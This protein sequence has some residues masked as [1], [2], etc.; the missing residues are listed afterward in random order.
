MDQETRFPGVKFLPWVGKDYR[1]S[2]RFRLRLLALGQ[3]HYGELF[4]KNSVF[5]REVVREWGQRNPSSYFTKIAQ[6]L[7]GET[8][9]LSDEARTDVWEHIAFYNYIQTL[10]DGPRTLP[11]PA[12]WKAAE[13]PFMV[14]LGA[15]QP[16]A[17]LVLGKGLWD[18]IRCRPPDVAF[19]Q[20]YDP[21][22][23]GMSVANSIPVLNSL[24]R[25]ASTRSRALHS[26]QT[27]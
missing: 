3:Y 13:V 24:L 17:V 2:S 16:N 10:A 21:S 4:T 14:V 27:R 6:V 23:S 15:L 8:G 26:I 19:A 25:R 5:T 18:H 9:C 7:L 11:S 12:E 22:Y 1:N 20:I